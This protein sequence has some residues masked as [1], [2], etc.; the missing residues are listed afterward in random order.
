MTGRIAES[1]HVII[2]A[3][4]GMVP[5]LAVRGRV[6]NYLAIPFGERIEV[7]VGR[8]PDIAQVHGPE[9]LV[10]FRLLDVRS[11][12]VGWNTL[13]ARHPDLAQRN[14]F[15]ID[16][17][18]TT[19][20]A[21]AMVHEGVL[22]LLPWPVSRQLVQSLSL[23]ECTAIPGIPGAGNYIIEQARGRSSRTVVQELLQV[24]RQAVA[25]DY[26]PLLS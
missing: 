23:M 22:A 6:P 15:K 12:A 24:L 10:R 25:T 2:I 16:A 1:G 14:T 9:D 21:L 26:D 19:P 17:V 4:S 11:H 5:P 13:L 18:E 3:P 7:V 20:L 8:P